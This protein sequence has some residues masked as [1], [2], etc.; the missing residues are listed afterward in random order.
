[1]SS[2]CSMP[3][4][5][6]LLLIVMAALA[7]C[8]DKDDATPPTVSSTSPVDG[9]TNVARSA[10]LTASFSEDMFAIT[11]DDTSFTLANN[12]SVSGTVSFDG[13]SNIA[14][15]EPT[16]S[17]SPL[18]TYSVNLSTAI[19]DLAGNPLETDDA[20]NAEKSQVSVDANGN[21]MA[22]WSQNDGTQS[23]IYSNRFE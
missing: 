1:M 5:I 20:G 12:G 4:C 9:A 10:L 16:T 23:N 17:L 11:F 2:S 15:F 21:I 22:V 18:A 3:V 7:G 19:T 14:S 6:S 8:S 13:V